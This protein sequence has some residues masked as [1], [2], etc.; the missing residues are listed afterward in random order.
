MTALRFRGGFASWASNS[1]TPMAGSDLPL[2]EQAS[3]H[4]E[5]VT[6]HR[7]LNILLEV[8][9]AFPGA[10]VCSKDPLEHRDAALDSRPKPS[11]LSIHPVGAHHIGDLQL[12]LLGKR[13]IFDPLL[14]GPLEI[15]LGGESA[16]QA[17]L[18][19]IESVVLEMASEHRF[20]LGLIGWIP[21]HHAS[22]QDQR[23]PA[24]GQIHLVAKESL[25]PAGA[26]DVAML[27]KDGDDF[28]FRR[29]LL[30]PQDPTFGLLPHL[31]Q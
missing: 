16:I 9:P 10:A 17:G 15:R 21:S 30:F 1:R 13:D 23:A 4:Q 5:V 31:L 27:L 12:P 11:Q 24:T 19:R 8:I 29:D 7:K 22:V 6:E 25:P 26:N 28:V 18:E 3:Q 20:H 14:L 2:Q